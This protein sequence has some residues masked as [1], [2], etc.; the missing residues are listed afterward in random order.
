MAELKIEQHMASAQA[1]QYHKLELDQAELNGWLGSRLALAPR[2]EDKP[3]VPDLFA[4]S[5]APTPEE[6]Q[7]NVKDVKIELLEDQLRAY[8]VFDFHGVDLTLVLEGRLSVESGYLRFQPTKGKLGLL[9]LPQ[10]S[11]K[12]AMQRLFDSPENREKFRLPREIRDVG[13]RDSRI[14]VSAY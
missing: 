13:I 10:A 3:V 12:S 9:P 4:D 2:N 7:S 8:V 5:P 1:G 11:L 6:L 14:Y